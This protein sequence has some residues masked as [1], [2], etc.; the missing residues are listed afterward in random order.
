MDW[1]SRRVHA[2]GELSVFEGCGRIHILLYARFPVLS[3]RPNPR[4]IN[5]PQ[6]GTKGDLLQVHQ[7]TLNIPLKGPLNWFPPSQ[8]AQ[9]S[10]ILSN[11]ISH[12]WPGP[13]LIWTAVGGALCHNEPTVSVLGPL[14]PAER[15]HGIEH[16]GPPGGQ[17]ARCHAHD[18]QCGRDD[19]EGRNIHGPDIIRTRCKR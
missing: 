7:A 13:R 16:G 10:P 14:F 4:I 2:T 1:F 11:R 6:G 18:E 8:G 3:H 15:A 9:K 12:D 19:E 5:C 17:I